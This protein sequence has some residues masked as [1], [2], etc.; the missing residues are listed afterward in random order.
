MTFWGSNTEEMVEL[1][2][3]FRDGDQQLRVT[4]EALQTAVATAGWVGPDADGFRDRWEQCR[5]QLS[6]T[7]DHLSS[8]AEHLAFEAA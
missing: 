8:T 5:Q 1:A 7:G 2:R 3:R 4:T 6:Q